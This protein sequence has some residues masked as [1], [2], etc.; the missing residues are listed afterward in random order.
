ME[1]F[2]GIVFGIVV[3]G[4]LLLSIGKSIGAPNPESM[5]EAAIY[6]RLRTESG[7]IQKY[8]SHPIGTQQT[9]S[10]K[11]MYDEKSNYT[12][13]LVAELNKRNSP[14]TQEVVNVALNG[15]KFN[16]K[17]A[18][19]SLIPQFEQNSET[20][21]S[22][23]K[24]ADVIPGSVGQNNTSARDAVDKAFDPA[25]MQMTAYQL[26]TMYFHALKEK[27]KFGLLVAS[28]FEVS[29]GLSEAWLD[30]YP[31]EKTISMADAAIA[32]REGLAYHERRIRNQLVQV[33]QRMVFD[34]GEKNSKSKSEVDIIHKEYLQE[35]KNILGKEPGPA[36]LTDIA[37]FTPAR[38]ERWG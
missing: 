28:K 8:L 15:D 13:M 16:S 36:D 20:A 30:S 3:L 37:S 14:R 18:I 9:E 35:I 19:N 24:I 31:P 6:Q 1:I 29:E 26:G 5:S 12:R 34:L 2:I 23:E 38:D 32:L 11:R 10:L 17:A 25:L 7:W 27:N 33:H 4:I 21:P 22:A